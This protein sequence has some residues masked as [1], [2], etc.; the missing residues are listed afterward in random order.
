ME[1][2]INVATIRWRLVMGLASLAATIILTFPRAA[3]QLNQVVASDIWP[4]GVPTAEIWPNDI[5]MEIWPNSVITDIASSLSGAS[6]G[7]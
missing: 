5:P 1:G 3:G 7:D 6:T 2:G 4:N